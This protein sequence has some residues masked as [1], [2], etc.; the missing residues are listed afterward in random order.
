MAPVIV[1]LPRG[2][3]V[4]VHSGGAP[5][6]QGKTCPATVVP[7]LAAAA[8]SSSGSGSSSSGAWRRPPA[9]A[10]RPS[11]EQRQQA[12]SSSTS[13][14]LP[15]LQCKREPLSE[16]CGGGCL[17]PR[18]APSSRWHFP[19]LPAHHRDFFGRGKSSHS[20]KHGKEINPIRLILL[21]I[22]IYILYIYIHM[23]MRGLLFFFSLPPSCKRRSCLRSMDMHCASSC[24]PPLFSFVVVVLYCGGRCRVA[25][26][27][28]HFPCRP[29]R[30]TSVILHVVVFTSQENLPLPPRV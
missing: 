1:V 25:D 4:C 11:T 30:C 20:S 29:L 3:V 9:G 24:S 23:Y 19:A 27:V 6:S 22:Y 17:L 14:P 2:W 21:Y 13:S 16:P 10:A 7:R 12:P 18:R 28:L 8:N 15:H 5:Q 26:T